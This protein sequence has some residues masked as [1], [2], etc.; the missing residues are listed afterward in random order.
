MFPFNRDKQF[1]LPQEYALAREQCPVA[2]VKLWN[3]QQA[4][5][6]TRY[7]HYCEVL[8]DDRFSGEFAREDFPTV[9]EARKAI[10]KLERAFVGMD[11]PRH[12]HFRRMFTKEFTTKR[13]MALKPKVEALTDGLLDRM[14]DQGPPAD[15]VAAIGIELPALVM[16]DLFGSPYEDHTYI[17]KCAAGRHGLGQSPEQAAQS[18]RDLVEYCRQLIAEKEKNPADDMLSRV[19]ED[20]I[21]PGHLTREELADTCSMILRAGHDTTTNMI[22]LGTLLLLEHPEELEKLKADPALVHSAVEE[23][24]RFL[25]PVQFAPRRVALEDVEV[26]GSKIEAGDGIFAISA[27]AN[28]D[29]EEFPDPDRFDITRDASHH[30]TF[31]YGIHRCLGQQLARIELH[32]VFE[33]LFKR[34][35]NLRL[36][37][38]LDEVPFKYDSQIYGLYRL[39]VAW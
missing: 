31:G 13:M 27:S 23:L 32:V 35:P 28:R 18:A 3:G 21:R 38:P 14:E 34:F 24:L 8:L 9:T 29:P 19:I 12:D 15:L 6:L 16:C 11:N 2:P 20:Q 4:W 22:G 37:V 36:A 17:A 10:D 5:L 30:V 25:T 33:K 39:P 26:D 1:E 7:K